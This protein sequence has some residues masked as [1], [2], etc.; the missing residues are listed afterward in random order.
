M[1]SADINEDA[2]DDFLTFSNDPDDPLVPVIYPI[3]QSP[4]GIFH[5]GDPIQLNGMV[6]PNSLSV[7]DLN[8]DGRIDIALSDYSKVA[9]LYH[10]SSGVFLPPVILNVNESP[11]QVYIADWNDDG[12]DDLAVI[13]EGENTS[14]P[15]NP[16]VIGRTCR[17]Q[18]GRDRHYLSG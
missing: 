18:S 15:N 7:G 4:P 16:T 9:V 17:Q 3:L 2:L 12:R 14:L 6:E 8:G 13:A 10:G 5:L 1:V 11:Q